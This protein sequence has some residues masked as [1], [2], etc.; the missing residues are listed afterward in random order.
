[1][2]PLKVFEYMASGKPIIC[3]NIEVLREVLEHRRNCILCDPENINEWIDAIKL[4]GSNQDLAK[5]LSSNA[6]NDLKS[7]YSWKKRAT[8]IS[9]IIDTI[10][11]LELSATSIKG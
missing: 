8:S 9:D 5:L 6:M 7:K 1:M 2:S 4:L 11:G 10:D 3:S